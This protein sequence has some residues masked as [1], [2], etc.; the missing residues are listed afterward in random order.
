MGG[1]IVYFPPLPEF[2][3]GPKFLRASASLPPFMGLPPRL[4]PFADSGGLNFPRFRGLAPK[5]YGLRLPG[6][7]GL[8]LFV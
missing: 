4:C 7:G 8:L 5:A 6:G 2:A 1:G 3:A